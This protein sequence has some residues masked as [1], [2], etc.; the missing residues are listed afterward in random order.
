MANE[1]IRDLTKQIRQD[2]TTHESIGIK[3]VGIFLR[4]LSKRCPKIMYQNISSLLSFFD[5][6]SYYLRQAII[7]ILSNIVQHV[8]TLENLEPE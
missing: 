3:N 6:E 4:K 2:N 7:K 8:L 5:C 1:I